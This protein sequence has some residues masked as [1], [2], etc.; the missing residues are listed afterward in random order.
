L[1]VQIGAKFNELVEC[2]ERC[3]CGELCS[4]RELQKGLTTPLE[5]Y[6]TE[7]KGWALRTLVAIAR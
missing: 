1:C 2:N 3:E 7:N 6:K 4:N 5:L